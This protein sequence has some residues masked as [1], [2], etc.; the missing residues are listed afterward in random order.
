MTDDFEAVLLEQ[1]GQCLACE[2]VI[3][4]DQ[5]ALHVPLIGSLPP[6]D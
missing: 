4:S 3:V 2:W 6:A 1:R 5:D